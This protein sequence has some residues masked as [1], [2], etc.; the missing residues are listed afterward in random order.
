MGIRQTT[1][2]LNSIS[3]FRTGQRWD[4]SSAV[5]IYSSVFLSL[6]YQHFNNLRCFWY[7]WHKPYN[8]STEKHL[9]ASDEW[10]QRAVSNCFSLRSV[11]ICGGT[12]SLLNSLRMTLCSPSRFVWRTVLNDTVSITYQTFK[13]IYVKWFSINVSRDM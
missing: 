5:Y 12:L 9:S 1:G 4:G 11:I 7:A 13:D 10:Y 6:N 2:Y 3:G 8:A